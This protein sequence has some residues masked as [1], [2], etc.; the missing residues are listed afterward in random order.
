MSIIS[1]QTLLVSSVGENSNGISNNSNISKYL[2]AEYL[3]VIIRPDDQSFYVTACSS[4]PDE[5]YFALKTLSAIE[6]ILRERMEFIPK[7]KDEEFTEAEILQLL[8]KKSIEI[9]EGYKKEISKLNWFSRKLFGKQKKVNQI[10]DQIFPAP[11]FSCSNSIL[12]K[13]ITKIVLSYLNVKELGAIS[14][15]GEGRELSTIVQANEFGYR[16][17][18]EIEA[19]DYLKIL[20]TG[21]NIC[22]EKIPNLKL[23]LDDLKLIK[24]LEILEYLKAK[25]EMR[26]YILEKN[27][28]NRT[29][30]EKVQEVS[31]KALRI[32]LWKFVEKDDFSKQTEGSK[33]MFYTACGEALMYAACSNDSKIAEIVLRSLVNSKTALKKNF[34]NEL[35]NQAAFNGSI[36][37]MQLLFNYGI[38]AK[39]SNALG[40]A[41]SD[42]YGINRIETIQLLL[43]KG[44]DPNFE[45]LWTEPSLD[46]EKTAKKEYPL[47]VATYMQDIEI[48]KLLLEYGVNVNQA[49][50]SGITPL[51]YACH[52]NSVE[53][54]ELL[55]EKGA[56]P[57]F[58]EGIDLDSD[59]ENFIRKRLNS[60]NI[61]EQCQRYYFS[62]PQE[63]QKLFKKAL[64][65]GPSRS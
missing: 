48:I 22:R 60:K 16:G 43:K 35:L 11:L 4:K 24:P 23:I 56:Y 33:K 55:L 38:K 61:I 47:I 32:V 42:C 25:P 28:F 40:S 20:C 7:E 31:Y 37:V 8:K 30:Y 49:N 2:N 53:I 5:E 18:D 52:D 39:G 1:R 3:N 46:W 6:R 51:M 34:G 12:P 63:I 13:E 36:D 15:I 17:S 14:K 57:S 50:S 26:F 41:F 19:E 59:R 21:I 10:Y 44:E 9:C 45:I 58:L 54:I 65:K 29:D 62:S 27:R 64:Q